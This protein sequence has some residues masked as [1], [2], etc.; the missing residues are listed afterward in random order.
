MEDINNSSFSKS[1]HVPTKMRLGNRVEQFVFHQ[2]ADNDYKILCQN[3]Q[4]IE[5]GVTLGELDCLHLKDDKITHT[6]IIYKF[7]LYDKDVGNSEIDHWIGPNRK[8][9]LIDK[10]QKLE[11][12]QLPLLNHKSTQKSLL[13]LGVKLQGVNQNVM[14]LA[15]LL[16]PYL[17][18]D[19]EFI[20]INKKCVSGKYINYKNL[21]LLTKCT[22][23]MPEKV[24]W[25]SEPNKDVEWK[26]FVD[27]E[28][29]VLPLIR[30]KRSPLCW[31][32]SDT[33]KLSKLFI[34]W[35]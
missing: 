31:V 13:N 7:Y 29:K 24:E 30:K 35:W 23:H 20:Q 8:D 4:I 25:L 2:L 5:D 14:F 9:S 3:L 6:E 28:I 33:E 12:K 21:D 26:S 32:K 16:V 27:F 34:T 1:I 11:K 19:V 15:Q 22:F 10:L 18:D 17:N